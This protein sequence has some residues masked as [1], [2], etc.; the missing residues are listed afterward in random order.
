M[1]PYFSALDIPLVGSFRSISLGR[2]ASALAM[3]TSFF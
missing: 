2:S 1:M 3:S